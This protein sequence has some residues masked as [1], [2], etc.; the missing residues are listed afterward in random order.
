[1]KIR[2]NNNKKLICL[3][4]KYKL[5]KKHWKKKNLSKKE[6]K[7]AKY[8]LKIDNCLIEKFKTRKY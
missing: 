6:T 3:F 7:K 8:L 4:K 2:S 1:M 5:I